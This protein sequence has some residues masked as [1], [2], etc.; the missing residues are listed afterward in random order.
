MKNKSNKNVSNFICQNNSI[1]YSAQFGWQ[2]IYG[3]STINFGYIDSY[4]SAADELVELMAPDLYLFPIVFNY[5]QYLELALKNICYQNLSKDDY[6]DFIRKSSHNLLKIWTQSKKFLSR[7]LKNKDLDFISEV[8]LFLNN[9]DK[10]SF[11][12]RYPEDK[13]MNPSIPNNLVINLKNL[14]TTIDEL[15]DLIYF[16]YGS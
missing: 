5:R 12:F 13:K 15:D 2:N 6:Q 7:N 4:K 8:I 1:N 16:T 10:N 3:K 11:N 14:K 9:L